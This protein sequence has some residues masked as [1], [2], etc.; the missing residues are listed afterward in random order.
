MRSHASREQEQEGWKRSWM[1]ETWR[2]WE[3]RE[4][5]GRGSGEKR[6]ERETKGNCGRREGASEGEERR[7]GG[8][9]VEVG[10]ASPD[11][12]H[13]LINTQTSSETGDPELRAIR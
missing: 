11:A 13:I 1:E 12:R 4:R 3:G 9:V 8:V 6:R 7:G 2:V 10:V 5:E